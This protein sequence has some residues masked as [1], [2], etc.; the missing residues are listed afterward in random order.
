MSENQNP[1]PSSEVTPHAGDGTVTEADRFPNPGVPE[2]KPRLTDTDPRSAK[3]NERLVVLLFLI[4]CIGTVGS[5]VAYFAVR[6]DGTTEGV[7]LSTLLLGVGMAVS[8]LGI[9]IAAV[10]WAK[11]LMANHVFGS[12]LAILAF[13]VGLFLLAWY[14]FHKGYGV[15]S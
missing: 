15:R 10:H 11:T 1:Q 4:S 12:V 6:P 5:I 14:L 13:T 9:G 2:H 7:R 8:L 3:R